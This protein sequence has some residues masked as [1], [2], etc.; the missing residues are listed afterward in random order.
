MIEFVKKILRCMDSKEGEK[1]SR[2][3][4]KTVRRTR[5][6]EALHFEYLY[7]IDSSPLG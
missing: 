3:L 5:P 4:G 1:V 7:I 2:S 6:E